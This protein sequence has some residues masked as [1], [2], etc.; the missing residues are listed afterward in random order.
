MDFRYD[1]QCHAEAEEKFAGLVAKI[2][3]VVIAKITN[4][5]SPNLTISE[6]DITGSEDVVDGGDIL[7]QKFAS[8]AVGETASLDGISIRGNSGQSA[9]REAARKGATVELQWVGASGNGY[10]LEGFFTSY[11]ETA[12]TAG[13][14]K[15]TSGFRVNDS[16]EIVAGS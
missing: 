1:L 6:E 10:T 2:D 4:L 12:S 7:H 8:I 15:F 16:T 14:F 13:T 3:D 11:Q 5:N 9:V